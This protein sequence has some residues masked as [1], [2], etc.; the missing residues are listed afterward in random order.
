MGSVW[1]QEYGFRT[2]GTA[3]GLNN[4]A[5]RQVYQDRGGFIWVSTENGIFRYDGDRF[6]SFGPAQGIPVSSIAAFGEAPDGSLLAGGG[7]GLYR[8]RGNH[9]DKVPVSFKTI[10]PSQGIESDGKGHTFLGT[11]SG[12]VELESTAGR[13]E[14][15]EHKFPQAPGTSGPG[16]DGVL[17]DG[18][19][20]WYGCGEELCRM[21][22]DGTQVFGRE[23]GLSN[24]RLM[25]V[26]EDRQGNLW[27]RQRNAGVLVRLAGQTK[28]G[29]PS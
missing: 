5:V 23:S 1:A 12:L 8:L 15:A 24:H 7:F 26:L 22:H 29:R 20:V 18:D 21:D 14:F 13:A 9:F 17:V 3:E 6:E 4:L 11:E 16:V 28:F 2:F 27:V 19:V 25:V 10:S